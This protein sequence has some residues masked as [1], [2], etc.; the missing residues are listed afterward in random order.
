MLSTPHSPL[1]LAAFVNSFVV[2][3]ATR[4]RLG[5]AHLNWYVAEELPIPTRDNVQ[6]R[7]AIEAWVAALAFPDPRF[8]RFGGGSGGDLEL[9]ERCGRC[10]STSASAFDRSSTH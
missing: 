3:W 4:Q 7:A 1:A 6:L 5:G 2:D 9:G 8:A 10:P